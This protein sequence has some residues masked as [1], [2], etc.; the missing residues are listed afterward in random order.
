MPTEIEVNNCII[1]NRDIA[2]PVLSIVLFV[3]MIYHLLN[4]LSKQ[5]RIQRGSEGSLEPHFVTKLFHF[6]GE[7]LE[8]T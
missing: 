1:S 2:S 7:Y 8:K 5:W 6:H 3:S 4:I